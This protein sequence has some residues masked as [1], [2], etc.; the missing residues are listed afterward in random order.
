MALYFQEAAYKNV[1]QIGFPA[2]LLLEREMAWVLSRMHIRIYDLPAMAEWVT[3]ETWPSGSDKYF[4]YRDYRLYGAE[5][6]LLVEATSSWLIIDL[7]KRTLMGVPDFLAG[8]THYPGREPLPRA[9]TKIKLP[10]PLPITKSFTVLWHQLDI[11]QHV[12]NA[13]YLTWGLEGLPA[14]WLFTHQPQT[15][16]ILYKSECL[17]GKP[18]GVGVVQEGEKAFHLIA[19]EGGKEFARMATTWKVPGA[20][21]FRHPLPYTGG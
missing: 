2:S 11:N 12:N 19:G 5:C 6:Q 16:D 14:D 17:Y 15:I 3:V 10:D 21:P 4:F 13:V 1:A 20:Y 18:V 7:V 9:S 8:F